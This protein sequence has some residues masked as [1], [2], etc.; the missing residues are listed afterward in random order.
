MRQVDRPLATK[1]LLCTR[2][3]AHRASKGLQ[4]DDVRSPSPN[5]KALYTVLDDRERPF[6][7]HRLAA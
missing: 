2:L 3:E 4:L 6:Y 5:L 1:S 7:E